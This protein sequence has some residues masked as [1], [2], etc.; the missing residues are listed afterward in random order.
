MENTKIISKV[1]YEMSF[2]NMFRYAV[3]DNT[4]IVFSPM[5]DLDDLLQEWPEKFENAVKLHD[6]PSP[7]FCGTLS[8][9]VDTLCAVFDI[10]VY[11]NKI[12]SLHVLFCLYA[13]IKNSQLYRAAN[14]FDGKENSDTNLISK[15][16]HLVLE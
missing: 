9:Y 10:P 7:K 13:A 2:Y 8:Q 4:F 5:P 1:I 6:I 14:T 12:Q 11:K 15:P 16:D 3:F